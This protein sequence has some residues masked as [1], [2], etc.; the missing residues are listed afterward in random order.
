MDK[1]KAVAGASLMRKSQLCATAGGADAAGDD[2]GVD[3]GLDLLVTGTKVVLHKVS[4]AAATASPQGVA[5]ASAAG[6]GGDDDEEVIAQ[7]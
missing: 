7:A 2:G 1:S 6:A 3:M 4:P 5:A